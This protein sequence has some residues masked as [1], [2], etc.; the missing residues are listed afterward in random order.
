MLLPTSNHSNELMQG[1]SSHIKNSM[2]R[3]GHQPGSHR[4][5]VE[6]R[7]PYMRRTTFR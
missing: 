6:H 3:S 7:T 4:S 1:R 2:R 5:V